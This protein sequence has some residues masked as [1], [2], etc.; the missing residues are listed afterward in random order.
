[1]FQIL[2]HSIF[3]DW[4]NPTNQINYLKDSEHVLH[5]YSLCRYLCR[6][7]V[8][9]VLSIFEQIPHSFKFVSSSGD[10]N[11]VKYAFKGFKF[12]DIF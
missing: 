8:A 3:L 10:E 1:M 11:A 6:L 7:S 12:F 9:F 4:T 5:M 2:L